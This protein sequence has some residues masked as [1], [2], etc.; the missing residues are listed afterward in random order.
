MRKF[1]CYRVIQSLSGRK[2]VNA[3]S[4]YFLIINV[5]TKDNQEVG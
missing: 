5:R 1:S 4:N 3:G 2:M